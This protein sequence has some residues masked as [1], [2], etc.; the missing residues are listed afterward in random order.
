MIKS[1]CM[2][3]KILGMNRPL[4]DDTGYEV[5]DDCDEIP[6]KMRVFKDGS[7]IC[8]HQMITAHRVM[9]DKQE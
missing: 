2:V 6:Y 7:N 8:Y 1:Q 9:V 5:F 4:R 3:R